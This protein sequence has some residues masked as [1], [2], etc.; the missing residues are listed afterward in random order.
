MRQDA[1]SL[2]AGDE[3]RWPDGHAGDAGYMPSGAARSR[4]AA[5]MPSAR[6]QLQ[7]RG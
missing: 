7:Q 6:A 3:L 5:R 4:Y 1:T 2:S